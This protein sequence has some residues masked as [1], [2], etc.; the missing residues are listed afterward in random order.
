MLE[1]SPHPILDLLQFEQRVNP[2]WTDERE[3]LRYCRV[4]AVHHRAEPVFKEFGPTFG[5]QPRRRLQFFSA[6]RQSA[7]HG[8]EPG[9][10]GS[11][12]A[13]SADYELVHW[14]GQLHSLACLFIPEPLGTCEDLLVLDTRTTGRDERH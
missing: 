9:N 7:K 4:H 13:G 8:K 3:I 6:E 12:F 1:D 2:L 5:W 10:H 11:L 14:N